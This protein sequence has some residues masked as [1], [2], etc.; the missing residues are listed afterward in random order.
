MITELAKEE[1]KLK[2]ELEG[3]DDISPKG[4]W[5]RA[6]GKAKKKIV[7]FPLPS[8]KPPIYIH[9]GTFKLSN[10]KNLKFTSRIRYEKIGTPSS[11]SPKPGLDFEC[12]ICTGHIILLPYPVR[13]GNSGSILREASEII[14]TKQANKHKA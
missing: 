14:K 4:S 3:V 6:K 8:T 10:F 1:L 9:L 5:K 13:N 11:C 7:S 12:L 2:G